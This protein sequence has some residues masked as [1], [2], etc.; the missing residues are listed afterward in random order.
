MNQQY[1]F[2]QPYSRLDSID[3]AHFKTQPA[4]LAEVQV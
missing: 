2:I 1:I 3:L 4:K